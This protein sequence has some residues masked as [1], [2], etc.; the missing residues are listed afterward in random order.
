MDEKEYLE[1]VKKTPKPT[2]ITWNENG[3]LCILYIE[4][5]DLEIV[6]YN[7]YNICNVYGGTD[8]SLVIAFSSVNEKTIMDVTCD[9][10]DV[11]YIKISNDESS[12][13]MYNLLFTRSGFWELFCKHEYVLINQ[14]DSY[15]FRQIPEKFFKYD[16]IG[17]P[18][19][20]VYVIRNNR[21]LNICGKGCKCGKCIR[22]VGEFKLEPS[23][24]VYNMFNGG[25]SLRKVSAMIYLCNRKTFQGEQED[26]YFCLSDINLPE[27]EESKEFSVDN[28]PYNGIPVG[29][30]KVW[31]YNT[32][33][34][35]ENLFKNNNLIN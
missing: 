13:K 19:G 16:Y 26:I 25:F 11:N 20:H 3:K 12:I 33:E 7:L 15:I 4:C 31:C 8:A 28:I 24:K 29:C 2:N 10:K 34:Y 1:I 30:H 21:V 9:W 14:W 27:V 18:C 32:R 17:A 23:E 5:R 6:P 22:K 35:I